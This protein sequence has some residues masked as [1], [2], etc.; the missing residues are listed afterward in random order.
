MIALKFMMRF[1]SDQCIEGNQLNVQHVKLKKIK[2]IH[3]HQYERALVCTEIK[4][5]ATDLL[6][7]SIHN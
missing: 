1:D 7:K 5:I 4:K 2:H 3:T 6:K